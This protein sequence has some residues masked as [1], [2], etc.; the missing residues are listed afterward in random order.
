MKLT[1]TQII[2]A[3]FAAT[4][5]Q[6]PGRALLHSSAGVTLSRDDW[7]SM[8]KAISHMSTDRAEMLPDISYEQSRYRLRSL[9]RKGLLVADRAGTAFSF[10]LPEEH[11]G[12]CWFRTRAILKRSGIPDYGERPVRVNTAMIELAIRQQLLTEFCIKMSRE[13]DKEQLQVVSRCPATAPQPINNN[14]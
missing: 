7:R 5:G 2:E 11:L 1:N 12:Q 4:L 8:K 6:L 14:D 10:W 3:V 9:E 13:Y